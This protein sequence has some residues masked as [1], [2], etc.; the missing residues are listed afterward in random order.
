MV[1]TRQQAGDHADRQGQQHHQSDH[2]SGHFSGGQV[3]R[4]QRNGGEK[5]D[6]AHNIVQRGHG[7]QGRSDGALGLKFPHDGQRRG[8]SRRQSD[9]A[10]K[11]G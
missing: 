2:V 7:D 1:K 5:Q 10:E 9:P 11:E 4:D 8:G 6:A 3:P